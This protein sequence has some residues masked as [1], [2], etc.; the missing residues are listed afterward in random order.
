MDHKIG[1]V[2][3]INKVAR[4]QTSKSGNSVVFCWILTFYVKHAR[5]C[6]FAFPGN[7]LWSH[8]RVTC[9]RLVLERILGG[10]LISII[11]LADCWSCVHLNFY[12]CVSLCLLINVNY[13]MREAH[14]LAILY[15]YLH[16]TYPDPPFMKVSLWP[17]ELSH[18]SRFQYG[19]KLKNFDQFWFYN[20][21]E[22]HKIGHKRQGAD[23]MEFNPCMAR[24]L[25][26]V[27]VKWWRG[28]NVL[29]SMQNSMISDKTSSFVMV[30]DHF[31]KESP[32]SHN[33]SL[34]HETCTIKMWKDKNTKT[35]NSMPSSSLW[36]TQCIT[37]R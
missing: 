32:I 11:S 27:E 25:Q 35:L 23:K 37:W 19:W 9:H 24:E 4:I 20:Q 17:F 10:V 13:N 30:C 18:L 2:I 22:R 21:H 5:S 15:Q 12:W 1:L 36:L 8:D 26:L 6:K 31:R 16:F 29:W 3:W 14:V 28:Y 34:I 7:S 33:K